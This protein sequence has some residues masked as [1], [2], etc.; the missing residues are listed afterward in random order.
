MPYEVLPHTADLKIRAVGKT[1]PE[2]FVSAAQGM[3]SLMVEDPKLLERGEGFSREVKVKAMDHEA[4]IVEWLQELLGIADI[5]NVYLDKFKIS[6]LDDTHVS[7][8]VSGSR[9]NGFAT[10]IKA[11]TYHDLKIEQTPEDYSTE[12]TFDI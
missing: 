7:T 4:L 8:Q 12:I 6:E 11:V 5:E 1:L 10:E 9:V 2:L 3:F